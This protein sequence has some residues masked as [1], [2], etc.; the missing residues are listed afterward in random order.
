MNNYRYFKFRFINKF[1]IDSLTKNTIYFAH[2]KQLNDPFD[3][4]LDIKKSIR[5]ALSSVRGGRAVKLESLLKSDSF[6]KNFQE[7]INKVGVCS[8]SL[9]SIQPLMWSHYANNHRG[10]CILYDIPIDFLDDKDKI[11]GV[12]KVSY[13]PNILTSWFEN[14]D[15]TLYKVPSDF[16]VELAKVVL[17]AKAPPWKYEEEARIIRSKAGLF[18]IPKEFIKQI[19]FGLQT[20]QEDKE[21]IKLIINRFDYQVT[22]CEMVRTDADFGIDAQEI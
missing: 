17:T 21:L 7:K 13:L 4:N 19:C 2:P 16:A 10:V 3:C 20:P 22:F 9:N 8:F 5:N 12:S 1:L 11:I 18:N 15:E 14:I 6:L